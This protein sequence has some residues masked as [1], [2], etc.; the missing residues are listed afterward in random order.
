MNGRG[1]SV[2]LRIAAITRLDPATRI[3]AIGI[4]AGIGAILVCYIYGSRGHQIS[5]FYVRHR[6]PRFAAVFGIGL[7]E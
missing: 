6:Y 2:N 7:R 1:V 5:T 3:K 4:N